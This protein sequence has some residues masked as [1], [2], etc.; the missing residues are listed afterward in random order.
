MKV[1]THNGIFHADEVMAIAILRLAIGD[2]QVIRSRD[3]LILANADILVDVGGQYEPEMGKFD[4]HQRGGAGTRP[5]EVPYASAGLIWKHYGE[6]AV[7]A[8]GLTQVNAIV[9]AV[10]TALIQPIDARDNGIGDRRDSP[11]SSTIS[12]LVPK[13]P[14]DNDAAINQA[15]QLAVDFAKEIL[16]SI[17]RAE[18]GRIEA[19]QKVAQVSQLQGSILVCTEPVPWAEMVKDNDEILFVVQPH[20]DG[21]SA[22]C[23]TVAKERGSF[24]PRKPLPERWAGLSGD[25]LCQ[26]TGIQGA[27]FCHSARFMAVA[28]S[29]DVALKMATIAAQV[30]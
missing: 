26:A 19:A 8:M 30:D 25:A 17:I 7:A 22:V 1:S 21:K 20:R 11:V 4:H 2:F 23:L 12:M 5:N 16:S 18:A 29:M 28:D 14:N 10:D 27:V 9:D 15:F 13:W 3:P 24:T 6:K